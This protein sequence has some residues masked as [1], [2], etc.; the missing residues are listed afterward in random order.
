MQS[1]PE[2]VFLKRRSRADFAS[3]GVN[4]IFTVLVS[5]GLT[6]TSSSESLRSLRMYF[7]SR[8][9]AFFFTLVLGPT[10]TTNNRRSV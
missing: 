9:N 6:A 4:L 8:E 3:Y 5:W 10:V 1:F 7:T 2:K